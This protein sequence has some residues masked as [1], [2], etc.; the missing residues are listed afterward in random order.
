MHWIGWSTLL[1]LAPILP[2]HSM[3]DLKLSSLDR[4]KSR[5][6]RSFAGRSTA[7]LYGLPGRSTD[8]LIRSATDRFDAVIDLRGRRVSVRSD[9]VMSGVW[10]VDDLIVERGVQVRAADDLVIVARQGIEILGDLKGLERVGRGVSISLA[11]VG[12]IHIDGSI[13]GGDSL[14]DQFGDPG[15]K[16]TPGGDVWING[17]STTL[18]G[19]VAGGRGADGHLDQGG[20]DGGHAVNFGSSFKRMEECLS[21]YLGG[22]AGEAGPATDLMSG[23]NGGD[24]GD[25]MVLDHDIT[26]GRAA[27]SPPP[28]VFS[29]SWDDAV[30]SIEIHGSRVDSVA[31]RYSNAALAI[32]PMGDCE[33]NQPAQPATPD[34]PDLNNGADGT[35]GGLPESALP[36]TDGAAGGDGS[37]GQG[38]NAT[39]GA[40]GQNSV[41]PNDANGGDAGH[42]GEGGDGK[43]GTG[44]TGQNGGECCPPNYSGS[45]GNGGPGKKG[46]KGTGGKGGKGGNGGSGFGLQC[47]GG[48]AGDGGDGGKGIG[49]DGG[50]GGNGALGS[51]GNGSGGP[52]GTRGGKAGGEHGD[53]GMAG[54]GPGGFG[55]DGLGGQEGD[56]MNGARGTPGLSPAGECGQ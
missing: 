8:I 19:L 25:G 55:S 14:R 13:V 20:G 45:G 54:S 18:R 43:G 38:G 15:T 52:R 48:N 24:G 23:A 21:L 6:D 35:L 11:A 4:T 5:G 1:T 17:R 27:Y 28:M 33:D 16:A 41:G 30:D 53:A 12:D 49:G 56:T 22:D 50:D 2:G 47:T 3:A 26:T 42:G 7:E 46:G 39:G 31:W 10:L 9:L 29:R 32:A 51:A 36:C 34:K 44:A 40:N 37:D